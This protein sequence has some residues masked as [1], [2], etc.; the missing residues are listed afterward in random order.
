MFLNSFR[1]SSHS[2]MGKLTL[3]DQEDVYLTGES[4]SGGESEQH[5]SAN[6]PKITSKPPATVATHVAR[7]VVLTLELECQEQR[8]WILYGL[9]WETQV[10]DPGSE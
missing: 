4:P 6:S 2:S 10:W 9:S 8:G 3:S 7:A 5:W 1:S